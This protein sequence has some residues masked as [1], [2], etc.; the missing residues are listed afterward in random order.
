[1]SII[2]IIQN[3]SYIKI[4]LKQLYLGFAKII[5][6]KKQIVLLTLSIVSLALYAQETFTFMHYNLTY[7]GNTASFAGCNNTNNN[8][9]TKNANLKLIIDDVLPDIF[10]VNELGFSITHVN[11][12]RD[13]A[14]NVNGRDYYAKT[15]LNGHGDIVNHL[16]FDNTKFGF[17]S[18]T[19][20]EKDLDD[21]FLT[22]PIDV[23]TLYY[24][25]PNLG[26]DT[27]YFTFIVAH[28]KAGSS[29]DN[30]AKRAKATDAVMNYLNTNPVKGYKFFM[31]DF[32]VK[33]SNDVAF[34]NII[35]YSNADINFVDPIDRL[36]DWSANS[37]FASTHTQSTRESDNNGGC[38]ITGGLDDR[39]DF[40]M[41]DNRML[42]SSSKLKYVENSYKALGNDGAA[43]NSDLR[44]S[45]NSVVSDTIAQ[46]LYDLSDHLPVVMK[47]E[48]STSTN[49]ENELSNLTFHYQNP[50]QN[51]IEILSD[52]NLQKEVVLIDITGKQIGYHT[53]TKH[54]K[55]NTSTLESGVYV[56]K[57]RDQNGKILTKK[58]VK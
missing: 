50:V 34:Q 52:D 24:K 27:T 36:G 28:L 58:L 29:S 41:M 51:E 37:S 4:V 3:L 10:T 49:V 12:I 53:F 39:Y 15:I 46:A 13:N 16:Y 32:N 55:I 54:L 20:I 26:T 1:M 47:V 6:M 43:Y 44:I 38:F 17:I 35:N 18:E 42:N 22:R 56:L 7:Y 48:L 19:L 8:V 33:S 21:Q 9:N 31:G 23:H 2:K 5:Q 30:E 25:D 11:S 40:I 57:I 14:L 45:N